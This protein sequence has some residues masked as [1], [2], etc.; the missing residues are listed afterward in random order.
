MTSNYEFNEASGFRADAQTLSDP[1]FLAATA[2]AS[3]LGANKDSECFDDLLN[4]VEA[5]TERIK[6]N[7]FS[8]MESILSGQA[9]VLNHLFLQLTSKGNGLMFDKDV[10]RSLPNYPEKILK[11]ALKAQSQSV[12]AIQALNDIKNPRKTT[13][14]REQFNQLKMEIQEQI[15]SLEIDGSTE[16]DG[17]T[18]KTPKLE[19]KGME[20]LVV[21]DG[22]ANNRREADI[23]S[24]LV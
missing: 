5:S 2:I 12:R 9:L 20:A 1:N 22:S 21:L 24:E 4:E 13:F 10:L 14:V 3:L 7:D 8:E 17:G 15:E 18:K 6:D 23:L 19:N 11:L 16:M